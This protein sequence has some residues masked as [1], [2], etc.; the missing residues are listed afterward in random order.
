M[1]EPVLNIENIRKSFAGKPAVDG[2]SLQVNKGEIVGFLGPN[3]A[4]KTTTLRMALGLIEPD[5]GEVS[6]FGQAPGPS[7]FGRIG[8]LPEERGLYRKIKARDA[9]AHIACLNGMRRGD[10]LKRADEM[11][12]RYGLADIK[13]KKIKTLSK[14]MA[15][16]VQL[17]AAI[18][19]DPEFLILDEPF[20][21][22]DPVNQKLLETMVREISER[23]RTIIFST[24]VMEHAERLCDKIILIS[25]GKKI[26]DGDVQEALSFAPRRLLIELTGANTQDILSGLADDIQ[27][28]G[29]VYH[30]VLKPKI[31]A[32]KVLETCV[33]NKLKLIRFEPERPSLHDAFVSLIARGDAS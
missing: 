26:F 9:I 10:A 7:A 18:A 24:H 19:H 5:S 20:S 29:D 31:N 30:L 6:L 11:L 16:K 8:F 13:H 21:G 17:I 33:K 28:E 12:G 32:Q 3:G 23:G 14:G 1:T 2:I 4:G 27:S 15:Q 25:Q 22:L